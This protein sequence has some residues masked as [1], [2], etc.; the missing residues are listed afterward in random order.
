VLYWGEI[1]ENTQHAIV[2]KFIIVSLKL[3]W[4]I[5]PVFNAQE[6]T[7]RFSGL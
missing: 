5:G 2:H 1:E 7:L 4:K 6:L 3:K